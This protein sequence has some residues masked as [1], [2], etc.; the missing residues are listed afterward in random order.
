MLRS[1]TSS[2]DVS[3]SS[4]YKDT[5]LAAKIFYCVACQKDWPTAELAKECPG[6][7]SPPH[8]VMHDGLDTCTIE[9]QSQYEDRT[10]WSHDIQNGTWIY[11]A[12]D[13]QNGACCIRA[14]YSPVQD[15]FRFL[16][17]PSCLLKLKRKC[18]RANSKVV[19]IPTLLSDARPFES[20]NYLTTGGERGENLNIPVVVV[21]EP[22]QLRAVA[23]GLQRKLSREQGLGLG[24]SHFL[25]L[26]PK[27]STGVP[28]SRHTAKMLP[29]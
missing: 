29:G 17:S 11:E 4:L 26:L 3:V 25:L 28:F 19:F 1:V 7:L 15:K 20:R 9:E 27:R 23:D 18:D 6:T 10:Q 16:A 22:G 13:I 2:S 8:A 12:V 14:D 24:A 5:T 21:C